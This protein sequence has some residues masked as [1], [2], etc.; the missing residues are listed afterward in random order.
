MIAYLL[1]PPQQQWF[2]NG[3]ICITG[4]SPAVTRRNLRIVFFN[5]CDL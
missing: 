2:T 4:W 5:N 3:S 1:V